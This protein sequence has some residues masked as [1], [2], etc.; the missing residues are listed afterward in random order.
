V[1]DDCA[2][3]RAQRVAMDEVDGIILT[4]LR[5]IGVGLDDDVNSLKGG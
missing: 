5:G 1:G 2:P 3:R 4:Q